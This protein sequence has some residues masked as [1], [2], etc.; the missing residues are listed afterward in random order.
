MHHGVLARKCYVADGP[1]G[2]R[3]R[4]DDSDF[5]SFILAI[6]LFALGAHGLPLVGPIKTRSRICR[7]HITHGRLFG[8]S[9]ALEP[10]SPVGFEQLSF[11]LCNYPSLS[12]NTFDFL[13]V[14]SACSPGKRSFVD[15]RWRLHTCES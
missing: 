9:A 7:R 2:D 1:K 13:L 15:W 12:V 5:I 14:C 3:E 4:L 8:H 10:L 11:S 6:F